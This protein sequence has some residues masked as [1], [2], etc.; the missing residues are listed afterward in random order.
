MA[1]SSTYYSLM[2]TIKITEP[3]LDKRVKQYF[4]LEK[5][6]K[7]RI[8]ELLKNKKMLV[9][10]IMEVE[11]SQNV[12][13]NVLKMMNEKIYDEC[14]HKWEISPNHVDEHPVYVCSNCNLH[15]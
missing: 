2:E 5:Q 12:L 3:E 8:E 7:D 6:S 13:W 11:N 15:K 10:K 14:P 9:R 1:S 4:R